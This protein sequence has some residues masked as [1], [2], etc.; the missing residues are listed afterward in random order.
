MARLARLDHG[1]RRAARALGSPAR[2]DRATAAASR[3][4]RRGPRGAARPRC[5]RRR[6]SRPLSVPPSARRGTP[7]RARSRARPR[8]ASRRRPTQPRAASG[9]ARP[10]SSPGASASTMRS[11]S[12]TQPHRGPVAVARGVSEALDHGH[13]VVDENRAGPCGPARE[14]HPADSLRL[15]EPGEPGGCHA[16]LR[17]LSG[18]GRDTCSLYV[19]VGSTLKPERRTGS[20]RRSVHLVRVSGRSATESS[21]CRRRAG[22]SRAPASGRTRGPGTV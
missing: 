1:L 10:R 14:L 20:S 13:T 22:A 17:P 15:C 12:T 6:S 18:L 19:G 7:A 3:R 16:F 21:A 9:P 4:P 8:R 2:P 11:P 5:R